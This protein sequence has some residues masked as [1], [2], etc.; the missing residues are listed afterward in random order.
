MNKLL[1]NLL[2][3][4]FLWSNAAQLQAKISAETDRKVIS[5]GETVTLTIRINDESTNAKPVLDPLNTDFNIVNVSEHSQIQILNGQASSSKQWTVNLAPKQ[6]G[7]ATIPAIQVSD[8]FTEPFKIEVTAAS[9]FNPQGDLKDVFINTFI[10]PENPYV[11]SQ[12]IYTVQVFYK[13]DIQ[14][15]QMTEPVANDSIIKQI[16]TNSNYQKTIDGHSYHVLERRYAVAPDKSGPLT[17]QPPV[18][19]GYIQK[20]E[21]QRRTSMLHWMNSIMEPFR[22]SANPILI[23]VKPIP[24]GISRTDWLPA[25]SLTISEDWSVSPSEFQLGQPITRTIIIEAIGTTAEKLPEINQLE[26]PNVLVYPDKPIMETNSN[27]KDLLAKRTEN[28]AIIPTKTGDISLPPIQIKWWNI[29]KDQFE[30]ASLPARTIQVMASA[31]ASADHSPLSIPSPT[32]EKGEVAEGNTITST[33][34]GL[35]QKERSIWIIIVSVLLLAWALTLIFWRR[36]FKKTSETSSKNISSHQATFHELKK[37]FKDAALNNQPNKSKQALLSWAKLIW[38]TADIR[39]LGDVEKLLIDPE[40]K[41][42]LR[43][44][45]KCLYTD[46]SENWNGKALWNKLEKEM[47]MPKKIRES[48]S[49]ELPALYPKIN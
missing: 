41:M 39:N 32:S 8:A 36:S 30:I 17:I 48:K 16:G 9:E 37:Q 23:D 46:Q 12:A 18:L 25:K 20:N 31:V 34:T 15:G 43:D 10:E 28:L 42:L 47:I 45:D 26:S 6:I 19:T 27:E 14:G 29:D 7:P 33:E 13:T 2:C 38:P 24:E 40:T 35:L 3:L 49:G 44:L 11:S 22:V 1:L 21:T 5:L 4:L